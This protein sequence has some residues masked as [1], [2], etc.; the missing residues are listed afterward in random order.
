MLKRRSYKGIVLLCAILLL[1]GFG[2][3]YYSYIWTN[4]PYQEPALELSER[5][6]YKENDIAESEEQVDKN[7]S[8]I[9]SDSIDEES[10]IMV[11]NHMDEKKVSTDTKLVFEKKYLKCGHVRIEEMMASDVFIDMNKHTLQQQYRAWTIKKF[12]SDRV[13]FYREIDDKCLSHYIVREYEGKIGVF[14]QNNRVDNTLKQVID[15]NIRQLREDDQ[16]KLKQGIR[17][18]SDLELGQ[19]IEDFGS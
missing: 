17:V 18:E 5:T 13:Q 2:L 7:V 15:I 1:V 12:S 8:S 3:G 14:Y 6:D 4:T 16:R 11:D 10:M 19:L 9:S